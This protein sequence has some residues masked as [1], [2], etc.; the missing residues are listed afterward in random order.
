MVSM[1]LL[2]RVQSISSSQK[3][4]KSFTRYDSETIYPYVPSYKRTTGASQVD[5]MYDK[6]LQ[7]SL[8]GMT[9]KKRDTGTRRKVTSTSTAPNIGKVSAFDGIVTCQQNDNVEFM[10]PTDHEEADT[11]V[12]LHV[13]DMSR[14]G[15]TRVMI[16]TVDTD[17]FLLAISRYDRLNL[18]QLWIDFGSGKQ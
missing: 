1:A 3:T 13:N 15:I 17:V 4:V 8:K 18:A 5:V 10:S 6:Y 12:F 16:R 7:K 14:K 9:S 2:L 11:R